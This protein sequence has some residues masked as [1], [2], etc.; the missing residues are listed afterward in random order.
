M[1]RDCGNKRF[2]GTDVLASIGGLL[3]LLAILFYVALTITL[4]IRIETLR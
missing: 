2:D 3:V 1:D 4:L